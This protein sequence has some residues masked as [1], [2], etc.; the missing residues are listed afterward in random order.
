MYLKD[1]DEFYN[2]IRNGVTFNYSAKAHS[3]ALDNI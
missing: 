1:L 3:P 2:E